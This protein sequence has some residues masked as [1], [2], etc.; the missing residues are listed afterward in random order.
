M[1]NRCPYGIVFKLIRLDSMTGINI[2]ALRIIGMCRSFMRFSMVLGFV[3]LY[4]RKNSIMSRLRIMK[5]IANTSV[6][7]VKSVYG[8]VRTLR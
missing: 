3:L 6:M 7:K 1:T 5:K 2:A 8:S 4:V